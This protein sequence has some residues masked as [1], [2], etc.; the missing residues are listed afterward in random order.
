MTIHMMYRRSAR[1]KSNITFFIFVT[2][3]QIVP[4]YL[5]WYLPCSRFIVFWSHLYIRLQ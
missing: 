2:N 5:E 4:T 3:V 1:L